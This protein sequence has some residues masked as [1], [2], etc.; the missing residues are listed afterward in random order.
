MVCKTIV[1]E[2][3]TPTLAITEIVV[4][5]STSADDPK[6][7]SY[8][9]YLEVHVSGTGKGNLKLKWGDLVNGFSESKT[10]IVSG[11]YA[12]VQTLPHGTHSICAELF[13]VTL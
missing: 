11:N 7:N 10:G 8:G 12:Y 6:N 3:V 5:R 13:G 4:E 2:E 9:V 1:I